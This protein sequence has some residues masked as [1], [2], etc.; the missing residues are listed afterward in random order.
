MLSWSTGTKHAHECFLPYPLKTTH[1]THKLHEA[2]GQSQISLTLSRIKHTSPACYLPKETHSVTLENHRNS[3]LS[4]LGNI[5]DIVQVLVFSR[6]SCHVSVLFTNLS[7]TWNDLIFRNLLLEWR[8]LESL[9]H[10]EC[11]SSRLYAHEMSLKVI[12]Q[13]FIHMECNTK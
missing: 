12:L 9:K 2:M 11:A 4:C 10:M 5:N 3:S 7:L 6:P 8:L 1:L 13:A